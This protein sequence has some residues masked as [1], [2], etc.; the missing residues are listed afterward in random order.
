M[1]AQIGEYAGAR[2]NP[3]IVTPENLMRQIVREESNGSKEVVIEELTIITKIGEDTLQRQ[4][5]KGVRAEE[6]AIGRP[7]F[8]S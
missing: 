8:V 3:E 7:L 2:S 6:K 4:V 1:I 5:I